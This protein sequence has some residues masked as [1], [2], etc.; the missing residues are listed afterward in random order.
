MTCNEKFFSTNF[1]QNFTDFCTLIYWC[2]YVLCRS[3]SLK[4]FSQ[5]VFQNISVRV[6]SR[7]ISMAKKKFIENLVFQKRKKSL[8]C[9]CSRKAIPSTSESSR[10]NTVKTC[11][12]SLEAFNRPA[13]LSTLKCTLLLFLF[14]FRASF[15]VD[16]LS[17]QHSFHFCVVIVSLYINMSLVL[18][19]C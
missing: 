14:S 3:T 7:L 13:Y 18:F 9:Y 2:K 17:R 19:T 5:L 10:M 6:T 4:L 1:I 15:L 11:Q 16:V 8:N 12:Q